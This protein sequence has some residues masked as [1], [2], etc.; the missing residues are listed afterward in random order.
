MSAIGRMSPRLQPAL[1]LAGDGR[2]RQTMSL[3]CCSGRQ[4]AR[5]DRIP[6]T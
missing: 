3:P 1:I 5:P 2:I 6:D 4:L